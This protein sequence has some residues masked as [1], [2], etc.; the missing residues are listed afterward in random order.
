MSDLKIFPHCLLH[1]LSVPVDVARDITRRQETQSAPRVSAE[2]DTQSPE[3]RLRSVLR[4]WLEIRGPSHDHAGLFLQFA[5]FGSNR[6]QSR[7]ERPVQYQQKSICCN[8]FSKVM[9]AS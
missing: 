2:G 8:S 3:L 6:N 5:K 4:P 7:T 1:S 9:R